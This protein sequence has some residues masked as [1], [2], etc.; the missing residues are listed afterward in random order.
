MRGPQPASFRRSRRTQVSL[1]ARLRF[2]AVT[3]AP[4]AVA[5]DEKA[6]PAACVYRLKAVML[7]HSRAERANPPPELDGD[8]GGRYSICVDY[9]GD[10]GFYWHRDDDD[11]AA[12]VRGDAGRA[13]LETHG[14]ACC[15]NAELPFADATGLGG[16]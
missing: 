9:G 12:P 2:D 4:R 3:G 11:A 5:P 6:P 13:L 16:R 14:H 10:D 7:Y 8:S 1:P 15:Y